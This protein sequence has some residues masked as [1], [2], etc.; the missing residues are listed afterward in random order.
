MHQ[1]TSETVKQT[2]KNRFLGKVT[3]VPGDL[4]GKTKMS[5]AY[6]SVPEYGEKVGKDRELTE[7]VPNGQILENLRIQK[8]RLI[9]M[10]FKPY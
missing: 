6:L 1:S 10:G 7:G 8:C 9:V 4:E 2:H 5:L 3:D